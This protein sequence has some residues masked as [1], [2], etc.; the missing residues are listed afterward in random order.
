MSWRACLLTMALC[1]CSQAGGEAPDQWRNVEVE[2]IPVAY[3]GG[4]IGRLIY[5]GGLDLR[6]RDM[7]FR[8]LSGLEVLDGGR[9]IAIGDESDWVE[10]DIVLDEV[11][12][13]IGFQNVRSAWLRDETGRAFTSKGEGDSEGL[14]QLPDGR[15]AVSFERTNLIRIYD[16]N[17]D[18]PFG[19][20]SMGP[21]LA[22][23]A[24]LR[25]NSGFEALAAFDDALITGAEG[26]ERAATPLW[27]APLDAPTPVPPRFEFPTAD[28]FS[29]TGMDRLPDGDF[30]AIERFYA[31]AV[32]VRARIVRFAAEA[33]R[34][35]SGGVIAV[36][37]LA[38]LE[39]PF[40]VDNFESISAVA[41]PNGV[42]RLYILTDNNGSARQRT[43]LIAFDVMEAVG[44]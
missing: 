26:G 21:R 34:A 29:L 2:A 43:L 38:L 32:G 11:G 4:P 27:L 25:P 6:S 13:L 30:V 41:M 14:A 37:E 42:T 36:E 44:D 1:A 28:G 8:G 23:T 39:R 18:G 33:L 19:A 31:P 24:A 20:A 5:R 12:A 3:A 35:E 9:L 17:R 40:P 15:F 16:L 22:G 10:A 7:T